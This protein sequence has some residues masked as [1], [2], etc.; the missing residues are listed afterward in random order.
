M[1]YERAAVIQHYADMRYALLEAIGGLGPERLRERSLDGW[2]VKDHLFHI[3]AWDNLRAGE[4]RRISAGFASAWRMDDE[5]D[6]AFN[7]LIHELHE[8]L[9]VEQA[10]WELGDSHERLIEAIREAPERGLDGSL[11]GEAGL[12]SHHEALHTEWIEHW[13]RELG[14]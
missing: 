7:R 9:D 12:M 2:S 8:A 3:A 14:Y 6:A 5:Q 10:L 11:Y 13:R 4:V 1:R